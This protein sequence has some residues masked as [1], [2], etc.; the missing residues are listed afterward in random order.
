MSMFLR[1]AWLSVIPTPLNALIQIRTATKRVSGSKTSNKDSAGRRL[2]PKVNEG[3]FVKPGQ[4]IMR[5]RG[6]RIHPGD[7]VKI[8]VDHTIYAIEPGYI[9]FYYDPFHPTRK[10]VGVSLKKDMKLPKDHFEPRLRRFGYKQILNKKKASEEEESMSRKELQSQPFLKKQERR[11]LLHRS[12]SMNTYNEKIAD[13]KLETDPN[14]TSERL[15]EISQLVSNY[16]LTKAREQVT[17]NK[18]YDFRLQYRLGKL[19]KEQ[20]DS[21]KLEYRKLADEVDSKIGVCPQGKLFNVETLPSKIQLTEQLKELFQSQ[22]I[23]K[24]YR[25]KANEIIQTPG[26]FNRAEQEKLTK[27]YI[28][29]ILPLNVP[30][31]VVTNIDTK[32]VPTNL[33]IQKIFDEATRKVSI[34]G[35]PNAV[36]S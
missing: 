23:T 14:L 35:R 34:I 1:S 2:G 20:F 24:E 16:G 36:F 10:Y 4:I 21:A 29:N 6:T 33:K 13:F 9:R 7:N 26:V 17:Y 28:P 27:Q 32:N 19:S 30:G 25:I 31:S 5:Q 18:L 11:N 8:G 15:F 12:R 3:H 22:A